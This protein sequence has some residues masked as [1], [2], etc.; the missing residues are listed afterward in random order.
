MEQ[1]QF[2]VLV[3]DYR[4]GH[5]QDL[6]DTFHLLADGLLHILVVEDQLVAA[7][8]LHILVVQHQVVAAGLLHIPVEQDQVEAVGLHVLADL[9]QTDTAVQMYLLL[10]TN[11]LLR[12][13]S[14]HLEPGQD[15][16]GQM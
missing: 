1:G 11:Q 14:G 13:F 2:P 7:G 3:H 12:E 9:D 16:Q 8:L 6:V 5:L 15:I 4:T 10:L